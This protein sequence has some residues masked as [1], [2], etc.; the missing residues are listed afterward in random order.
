ML[1]TKVRKL[2][3]KDIDEAIALYARTCRYTEYFKKK[4]GVSDC[5]QKIIEEFTPDVTAAIRTGLCLGIFEKGIMIGCLFS[6]DWYRYFE[7]E[8]ALFK[9]MFEMDLQTTDTIINAA[10]K[11]PKCYFIFAL[12]IADGK[13]CQGCATKMLKHYVKLVPKDVTILTDCLYENAMSLW[14]HEGFIIAENELMKLA[15]KTQ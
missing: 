11:F 15:I 6:I 3:E 7:E 14:L 1:F 5:E 13:R 12:G 4:F 10:C 8:H 9:H 2:Q